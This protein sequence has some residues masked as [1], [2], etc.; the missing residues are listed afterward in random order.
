MTRSIVIAHCN[1]ED[2]GWTKE[3]PAHWT[4]CVQS[5]YRPKGREAHA[6]LTHIVQHF[7]HLDDVIVFCQGHPFDHDPKFIEHLETEH[8][9]GMVLDCGPHGEEQCDF[10]LLHEFCRLFELPVLPRYRFVSG[11]QFRVTREQ[12]YSHPREFYMALLAVCRLP[13]MHAYTMERLWLHIFGI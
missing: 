4:R 2:I 7:Y 1:K 3:V 5:I 6:Y 9:F 12:V 13:G 8:L 11:A 10:C